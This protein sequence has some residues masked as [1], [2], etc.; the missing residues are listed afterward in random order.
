MTSKQETPMNSSR[1]TLPTTSLEQTLN[2][3]LENH[4]AS[5]TVNLSSA[6]LAY[7]EPSRR[8]AFVKGALKDF[9]KNVTEEV[10]SKIKV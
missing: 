2:V 3:V 1:E 10:I 4:A 9:L 8:E 5:I 6:K 7:A